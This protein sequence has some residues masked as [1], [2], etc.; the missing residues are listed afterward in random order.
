VHQ[1]EPRR[2]PDLVHERGVALD[3]RLAERDVAAG[4]G[5]GEREAQRV[6]AHFVDDVE[7]IDDVAL[8]LRHLLPLLVAHETVEEDLAERRT[9]R[10]AQ[11]HHDHARHPEEE[12]VEAG[13]ERV[14]RVEELEVGRLIRPA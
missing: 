3:A 10:E 7:R 12:D 9:A 4:R 11:A 13:D 2:V 6:G 14:G 5:D 1:R 8:R